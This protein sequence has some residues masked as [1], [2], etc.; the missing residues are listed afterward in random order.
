MPR[1]SCSRNTRRTG[2]P[3]PLCRSCRQESRAD[4]K[5]TRLNSSHANISY[6]VFCLKKK[7]VTLVLR[8]QRPEKTSRTSSQP[9]SPDHKEQ[10]DLSNPCGANPWHE[11]PSRVISDTTDVVVEQ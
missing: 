9:P 5:S 11:G 3:R 1:A 8:L 7:Q 2:T 10:R 6:A 4:R